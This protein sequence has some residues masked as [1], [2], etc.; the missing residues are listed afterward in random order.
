[1]RDETVIEEKDETGKKTKKP[2]YPNGRF[3]VF[4]EDVELDDKEYAYNHGKPPWAI[5]YDYI[6]PH[7]HVGMGEVQQIEGQVL[8]YNL[9]IRKLC[10]HARMYADLPTI[11]DQGSG[12]EA[13]DWKDVLTKKGPRVVVKATGSDAPKQAEVNSIDQSVLALV[14]GLPVTIRIRPAS[15]TCPR[16]DLQETT[17]VRA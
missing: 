2:K 7:S 12:I 3:V 16:N 17:S 1:M 13:E 8:E 15:L 5:C 11:I 10:K 4:C 6:I 14:N 9:M